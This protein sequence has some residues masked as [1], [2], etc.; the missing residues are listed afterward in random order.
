MMKTHSNIFFA[1]LSSSISNYNQFIKTTHDQRPDSVLKQTTLA[2]SGA[3][4]SAGGSS[5]QTA[6]IK[7]SVWALSAGLSA[8]ALA[9]INTALDWEWF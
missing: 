7:Y 2:A 1:F 4:L 5:A 9:V 3:A 8:A 6:V